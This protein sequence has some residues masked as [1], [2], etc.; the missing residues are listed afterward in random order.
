MISKP[1]N[2]PEQLMNLA[3]RLAI[4]MRALFNTINTKLDAKQWENLKAMAFRDSVPQD[5]LDT[6]TPDPTE[7][8]KEKF[9][10]KA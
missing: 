4:E 6:V 7:F 9:D 5:K 8:F 10:G 1:K 2:L 3:E